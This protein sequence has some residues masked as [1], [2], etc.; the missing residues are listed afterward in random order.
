MLSESKSVVYEV[1]IKRGCC[2]CREG[3]FGKLCKHQYAIYN[4]FGIVSESFPALI[5]SDKHEVA[6]LA[7]GDKAPPA[8]F[9]QP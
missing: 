5:P 6:Y 4:Y 3:M 2:S 9:Y 7:L 8:S 1:N